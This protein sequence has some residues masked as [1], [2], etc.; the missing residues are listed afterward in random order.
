MT[1]IYVQYLDIFTNII[2][3]H[4]SWKALVM[5]NILS[6]AKHGDYWHEFPR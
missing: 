2:S 6:N 4:L 5:R 3:T 1:D